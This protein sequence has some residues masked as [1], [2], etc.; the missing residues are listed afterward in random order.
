MACFDPKE[1]IVENTLKTVLREL[2]YFWKNGVFT[3]SLSTMLQYNYIYNYVDSNRRLSC[4]YLY[5]YSF[6]KKEI[7]TWYI[8]N[9]HFIFVW[10]CTWNYNSI[11]K[12]M[13]KK[14]KIIVF[15]LGTDK[16]VNVIIE[17][18]KKFSITSISICFHYILLKLFRIISIDK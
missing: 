5:F 12:K 18:Y 15:D 6:F 16:I 7:F 2:Y 8:S 10:L 3:N 17:T 1:S 11:T 4:K 14:P 13:E 9:N